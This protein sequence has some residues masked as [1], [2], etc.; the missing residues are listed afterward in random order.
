LT[1]PVNWRPVFTNVASPN[2]SWGFIVSN[3]HSSP[4]RFYR[5]STTG[6]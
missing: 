5:M 4:A 3:I 1:P 2:G 6:H